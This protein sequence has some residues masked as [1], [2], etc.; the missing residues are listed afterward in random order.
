MNDDL[1]DNWKDQPIT[2]VDTKK[3]RLDDDSVESFGLAVWPEVEP[4]SIYNDS[5]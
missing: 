5:M 1:Q 2:W 4:T 3:K